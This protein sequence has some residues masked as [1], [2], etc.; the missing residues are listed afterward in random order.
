MGVVEPI[1][2]EHLGIPK[3]IAVYLLD[4]PEGPALFDCGPATCV[5]ALKAALRERGLELTN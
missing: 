2:L 3:V 4:T 5:P 1:D